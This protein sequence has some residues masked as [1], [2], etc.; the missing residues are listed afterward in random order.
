MPEAL[1]G[2]V[3]DEALEMFAERSTGLCKERANGEARFHHSASGTLPTLGG[4]HSLN[5]YQENS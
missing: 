1:N 2:S 4:M 5:T 3:T